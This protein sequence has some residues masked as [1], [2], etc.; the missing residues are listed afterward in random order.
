MGGRK[1]FKGLFGLGVVRESLA[2]LAVNKELITHMYGH[3]CDPALDR[4]V[5][6]FH[7]SETV[8]K[9]KDF[10]AKRQSA[11][12]VSEVGGIERSGENVGFP[13]VIIT[14]L[15]QHTKVVGMSAIGLLG[16]LDGAARVLQSSSRVIADHERVG[17]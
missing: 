2:P 8:A 7:T 9:L 3:D 6:G 1:L 10:P 11:R 17:Q 4:R 12:D 15:R 13:F 5:A 16:H 14:Q